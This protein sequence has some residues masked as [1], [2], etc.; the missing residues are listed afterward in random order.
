[1]QKKIKD[2]Y[3]TANEK[4]NKREQI[5]PIVSVLTINVNKLNSLREFQIGF[6]NFQLCY[7]QKT[8]L[9]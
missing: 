2:A 7:L 9:K 6:K 8:Y 1:M 3:N 4:H 5:S